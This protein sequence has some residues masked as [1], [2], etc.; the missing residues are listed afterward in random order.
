MFIFGDFS[1]QNAAACLVS[2]AHRHDHITP[3]LVGLHWLPV[4]QRIVYKKCGSAC[5]MQPLRY[6]ADLYMPEWAGIY[7]SAR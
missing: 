6:L 4:R 5:T 3:V 2:G 1:L 7:R